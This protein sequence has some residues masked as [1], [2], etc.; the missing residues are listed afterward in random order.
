[1]KLKLK[2]KTKTLWYQINMYWL[3]FIQ[4]KIYIKLLKLNIRHFSSVNPVLSSQC[5]FTQNKKIMASAQEQVENTANQIEKKYGMT[6]CVAEDEVI[7]F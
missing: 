2:F 3:E 4:K 1:M 5:L 6:W 7:K